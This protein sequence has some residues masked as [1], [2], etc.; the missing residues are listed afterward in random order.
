M[1]VS[2]WLWSSPGTR[3]RPKTPPSSSTW[4]SSRIRPSSSSTTRYPSEARAI[5]PVLAGNRTDTIAAARGDVDAA[6]RRRRGRQ[7][8]VLGRSVTA[9][10]RWSHGRWSPR[11]GRRPPHRLGRCEGQAGEPPR[12]GGASGS[13]LDSIRFFE[14]D[15]GGGFG[16]RGEFYPE[17]F[18]VPWAAIRLGRPVKWTEDR[19]ENLVALN[20]SARATVDGG[21]RRHRRGRAAGAPRAGTL[22]PGRVCPPA[23]KRPAL[24][25]GQQ[26]GR[27]VPLAR[28]RHRHDRRDH[29]QDAGR[30]LSRPGAVRVQLHP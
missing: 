15:V 8:I 6:F 4:R 24:A 22:V 29:E 20:Q 30:H 9:R 11:S 2:Q 18:L 1:S 5:H 19:A 12:P 3:T 28:F 21:G 27:P 25:D 14:T 16:G 17:D 10:F 13:R 26:P 23:R 7:R